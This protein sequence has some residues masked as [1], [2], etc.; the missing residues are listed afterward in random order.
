[1]HDDELGEALRNMQNVQAIVRFNAAEVKA[2]EQQAAAQRKFDM[3]RLASEFE[4]AVGNIIETVSSASN[5]LESSASTL[6]STATRSQQ[7]AT[8]VAAAS[9]EASTN[10]QSVASAAEE[11]TSS[12]HEISRQ[13]QESA[14]IA[15]GAVEQARTT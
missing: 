10:V 6:S 13:V 7:L 14:R 3:A 8:A 15:S 9:E 11:L 2:V 5:D 1:E 4:G 12:V